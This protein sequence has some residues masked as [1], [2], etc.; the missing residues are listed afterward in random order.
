VGLAREAD[1][2][3]SRLE[4]V[5]GARERGL[6][7]PAE[8]GPGWRGREGRGSPG[9]EA[10]RPVSH[11]LPSRARRYHTA[12]KTL[13]EAVVRH[14]APLIAAPARVLPEGDLRD[15]VS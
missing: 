4:A 9:E 15:L 2:A 3:L 12:V 13:R 6:G 10:H 7:S 11:R 5:E 8:E 1:A 14:V